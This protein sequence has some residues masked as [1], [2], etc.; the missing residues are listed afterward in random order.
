MTLIKNRV[1]NI[2][3]YITGLPKETF[4][5]GAI[6][7]VKGVFSCTKGGSKRPL[8]KIYTSYF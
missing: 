8:S 5:T 4:L 6:S 2:Y 7:E 3:R 1:K